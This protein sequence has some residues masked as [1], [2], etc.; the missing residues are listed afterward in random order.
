MLC[1]DVTWGPFIAPEL[2]EVLEEVVW[3]RFVLADLLQ[4]AGVHGFSIV[5]D[6][7]SL[8]QHCLCALSAEPCSKSGVKIQDSVRKHQ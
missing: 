3:F 1:L 7:G 4:V 8:K 6:R 2:W 5:F